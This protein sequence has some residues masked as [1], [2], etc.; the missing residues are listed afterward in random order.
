MSQEFIPYTSQLGIA[1]TSYRVQL[2]KIND[3]WASR[4]LKGKD[5]IDSFVYPP[6]GEGDDLPNANRIVGWILKVCAIPMINPYQISKTVQFLRNEAIRNKDKPRVTASVEEAKKVQLEKVPEHE[7]KR[8]PDMG[9]VKEDQPAAALSAATPEAPAPAATQPATSGVQSTPATA[10]AG[11][12]AAQPAAAAP[13]QIAPVTTVRAKRKLPAI[14]GSKP[15][16][17]DHE[18]VKEA[19]EGAGLFCVECGTKILYCPVCGKRL[20]VD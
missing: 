7:K 11:G 10:S 13:A 4:L 2:G 1:G 15:P 6:E 16:A 19:L 8:I 3:K 5:V 17:H 9:W 14:P 18:D 20:V 12:A